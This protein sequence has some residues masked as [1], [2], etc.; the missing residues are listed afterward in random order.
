MPETAK[1]IETKAEELEA[2]RS[3]AAAVGRSRDVEVFNPMPQ[4]VAQLRKLVDFAALKKHRKKAVV[5]LMFGTGRG[6]LDELLAR[7]GWRV[8]ALHREPNPLFGNGH[9]EPIRENMG[10]LLARLQEIQGGA[11]LGTRS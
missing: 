1:G 7:S 6:Y 9:P 10:E 8:D 3:V 2:S 11:R 4:Y 5:D